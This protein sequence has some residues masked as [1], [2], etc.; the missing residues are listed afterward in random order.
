ML[1][2]KVIQGTAVH[3]IEA[4]LNENAKQGWKLNYAWLGADKLP[5]LV[6]VRD[7]E[8]SSK[9]SGPKPDAE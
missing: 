9:N 7:T 3:H 1:Q 2:Y 4:K 5:F 6:L 8:A